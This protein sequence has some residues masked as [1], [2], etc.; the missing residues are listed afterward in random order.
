MVL[1]ADTFSNTLNAAAPSPGG[2][3]PGSNSPSNQIGLGVQIQGVV[4]D[5]SQGPI[6]KTG[7]RS[8]L[9]IEGGGFFKVKDSINSVDYISRAGTFRE[10]DRG[11]LV[12]QQQGFRLQGAVNDPAF[13]PTYNV[14]EVS[15]QLVF[16]KVTPSGTPS[17]PTIGDLNVDYNLAVGSGIN[18]VGTF[19]TF[20]DGDINRAAP[21]FTGYS[22]NNAG[23]VV[24]QL[25]NN[26]SFTKGSIL[27]VQ[28]SDEQAL[29]K[30]GDN[31]YS[32]LAAAGAS[33]FDVNL[34]RAN[35]GKLG[36]IRQYSL[37]SSNVNLTESF[38]KLIVDQRY[39]QAGATLVRTADQIL[40]ELVNLKR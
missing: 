16:T 5:F 20:A 36:I 13:Y 22:I 28:V 15:G 7:V 12:T 3:K 14:S 27:L 10:D 40:Q 38:S 37:E 24:M 4:N 31:L 25:S 17:A 35:S 33:P 39:Y 32:G 30:Q 8:H 1:T 21:T 29:T 11:Y 19:S 26:D 34:S 6:E 23:D 9:A 2:N 18:K